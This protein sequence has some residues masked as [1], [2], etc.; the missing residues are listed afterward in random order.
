MIVLGENSRLF[1][2]PFPE[3]DYHTGREVRSTRFSKSIRGTGESQLS[4]LGSAA[5]RKPSPRKF[6]AITATK[7]NTPGV[8]IQGKSA[9]MRGFCA[10][11][12]MFPQLASGS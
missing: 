5:S 4:V 3:S 10:A 2:I 6:H 7:I 1:F 8:N 9:R 12:S 11:V